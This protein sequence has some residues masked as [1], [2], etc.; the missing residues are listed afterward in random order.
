[1]EVPT[2]FTPQP[3]SSRWRSSFVHTLRV[4]CSFIFLAI[5]ERSAMVW[6][7]TDAGIKARARNRAPAVRS[8][9]TNGVRFMPAILPPDLPVGKH[10][11]AAAAEGVV[12]VHAVVVPAARAAAVEAEVGAGRI[13]Q[14]ARGHAVG[15]DHGAGA[16][17]GVAV[18]AIDAG[19]HLGALERGG[20]ARI[21][22]AFS[23]DQDDAFPVPAAAHAQLAG[24][25]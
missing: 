3:P 24:H 15:V 11:I 12:D 21:P 17:S 9:K 25:H 22:G 6:A 13:G 1:M 5:R 23:D 14:D 19:Q 10:A 4:D 2:T 18:L 8:E 20:A 16:G 7:P